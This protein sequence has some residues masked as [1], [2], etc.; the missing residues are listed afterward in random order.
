MLPEDYSGT[1]PNVLRAA[2]R[3]VSMLGIGFSLVLAVL[4]GPS[5]SGG[6]LAVLPFLAAT[7][8][9]YRGDQNTKALGEDRPLP[10]GSE[11]DGEEVTA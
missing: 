1:E 9:I 5:A 11:A 2:N 7:Y 4:T 10:D 6:L 3:I 8:I